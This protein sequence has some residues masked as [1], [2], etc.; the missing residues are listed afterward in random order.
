MEIK[1][2]E[3]AST[4]D[5]M[6]QG[7]FSATIDGV[8][9]TIIY[10]S[11]YLGPAGEGGFAAIPEPGS[12]ILVSMDTTGKIYYLSTI[13]ENPDSGDA[14]NYQD[15]LPNT[16][17]TYSKKGSPQT[18]TL[19]SPRGNRLVLDDSE[20]PKEFNLKA[21]L[22]SAD[23]KKVSLN[24]TPDK[25]C[26]LI[27]NEYGDKIKLQT[28]PSNFSAS[29]SLEVDTLGPQYHLCRESGIEIK[30][31]EGKEIDIVNE[32]NG[33]NAP[34]YNQF[35]AG[36]INIKSQNRDVNVAAPNE[37]GRIFLDAGELVQLDTLTGKII[38]NA[39]VGDIEINAPT[40]SI[41]LNAG[42][43]I[44][45]QAGKA[46]NIASLGS[47]DLQ[48]VLSTYVFSAGRAVFKGA[49]TQVG[50]LGSLVISS[51]NAPASVFGVLGPPVPSEPP[52]FYTP[53]IIVP[54]VTYYGE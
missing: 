26:I 11:P 54:D 8:I 53:K 33:T 34:G 52:I 9:R 21:E 46:I 6:E 3:V 7:R 4:V 37:D 43:E 18:V 17:N 39:T 2:A 31:Q 51:D 23:G 5:P 36:N 47:I 45:L 27:R 32:S 48:S 49:A 25:D 44:N 12:K 16:T 28:G 41:T 50:S 15:T 38:I 29:R 35:H 14:A 13:A 40:G 19:E 1:V 10:T 22:Q 20:N 24:D 42:N 30:V